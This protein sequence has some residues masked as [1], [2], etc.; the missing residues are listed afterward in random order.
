MHAAEKKI[1]VIKLNKKLS[2]WAAATTAAAT[3]TVKTIIITKKKYYK[4]YHENE[5]SGSE[6]WQKRRS[7]GLVALNNLSRILRRIIL[8]KWS[9]FDLIKK[10]T[11]VCL[12]LWKYR[13]E[14]NWHESINL[15]RI[16]YEKKY[17]NSKMPFHFRRNIK[18]PLIFGGCSNRV[19]SPPTLSTAHLAIARYL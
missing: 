8:N 6:N 10:K 14:K 1:D 12:I 7:I 15:T 4:K 11:F 16:W 17:P 19:N 2:W 3:A 5:W 9:S 18:V 13:A